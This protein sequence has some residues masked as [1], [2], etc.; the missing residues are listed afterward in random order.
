MVERFFSTLVEFTSMGS[1]R[2]K[3]AEAADAIASSR[4]SRNAR[5]WRRLL[6]KT[7]VVRRVAALLAGQVYIVRGDSMR[8][9][10][11]PGQHLLVDRMAYAAAAPS[12]GDVVIVHDPKGGG[13]RYLKRVVG[14][15]GQELRTEDGLLLIDGAPL[16]EPYL[17]GLPASLGVGTRVWVLGPG[18]YFVLGDNRAHSTDSRESGPVGVEH[19]AGRAR[20][21]YWPL[22]KWGRVR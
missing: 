1:E 16:T 12:T 20:L 14:V 8:P 17:G 19:I 5:G 2:D 21:R 6:G 18:Q 10:F 7:P 9:T 15:P 22:G 4:G 3:P 13:R 11:E